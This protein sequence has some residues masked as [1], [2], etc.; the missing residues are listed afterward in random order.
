MDFILAV[1]A[2]ILM[3]PFRSL[4]MVNLLKAIDTTSAGRAKPKLI[5]VSSMGMGAEAHK[6]LAFG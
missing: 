2:R 1:Y 3:L 4:G 6:A 5:V